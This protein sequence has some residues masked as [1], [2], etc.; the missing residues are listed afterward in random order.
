MAEKILIVD[1]DVETLRLVGMMLQRQGYQ[2]F[3]ANNGAQAL[4]MAQNED[5]D[6][7][8]LDVMMPDMDGY[9]VT[10]ELRKQPAFTEVPIMMFTA[11]SQVDDKVAGY[12]VGV[13]DYLTKPVHPAELIAHLKS[14]LSRTRVRQ[15]AAPTTPTGYTIGIVG[16]KGGLGSSTLAL[17][18]AAS[19]VRMTQ[20][21]AIAIELKPGQGTWAYELGFAMGEG[22]TNLLKLKTT[23][24]T[25]VAVEQQLTTTAFGVRLLLSSNLSMDTDCSNL[26]EILIAIIQAATQ[27]SPIVILDIGTPFIPGFEKICALCK[28][29]FLITEP[30]PNTIKRTRML[31]EELRT[32]GSGTGRVINLVLYN[33]V[34]SEVQL[35]SIQVSEMMGG[36]PITMMI[37]PVPEL[38]YQASVKQAPMINLQPEGLISQQIEQLAKIVRN[39]MT[40]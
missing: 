25:P 17:N 9:Q 30:Q 40:K 21:D 14:L 5:P 18:L 7:I 11:K 29:I 22:L 34:R 32:I 37:P 38:A 39:R 3:A 24:I 31:Y 16:C 13:D 1:D 33:R 27:L 10:A 2:I 15:S 19:Y 28:E 26:S 8:I 4:S 6:L 12:N 35:S 20:S 36:T 23:E